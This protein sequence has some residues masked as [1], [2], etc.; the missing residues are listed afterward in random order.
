MLAHLALF[1]VGLALL[2][3][4]GNALVQGAATLA[5]RLRI[6]PLVI[7]LTVVAWGTGA[8]ELAVS[9]GATLQG[10]GDIALG[11]VV[12]SNIINILGV[13]GVSALV[14]P[15]VVSRRLVRLDVPILI[16]LSAAVYVLALNQRIGRVDGFV[17]VAAGV[18]YTVFAI[19]TSREEATAAAAASPRRGGIVVEI[20][21]VLLG[22]L[23]VTVGARWLVESAAAFARALGVSELVIGL[24]VVAVGTSLPEIAASVVA[25]W[26]GERDIAVGNAVGSNLFNISGVLGLTGL[27]ARDGVPVAAAALAFDIPVM[28]AAA[29][30]CLPVFFSGQAVS[31]W[32]GALF[33][34]YYGAYTLYLVLAA[35]Q[36]DAVQLVSHSMVFFVLP[37]TALTLA[38]IVWRE[39]WPRSRSGS[40]RGR[41]DSW[42]G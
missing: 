31:R 9:L 22:L 14:A 21:L 26:R 6:S 15:L 38:V 30:A 37:L 5:A 33:L 28:I 7:G 16:A 4:G 13:L 41:S 8:P 39:L 17:L 2:A 1:L 10:Q 20:G 24:T 18:G 29:V 34:A 36:H 11:N 27:L 32:E 3:F 19:R 23:L 40:A 12:G 42:R 25:A 35:Q